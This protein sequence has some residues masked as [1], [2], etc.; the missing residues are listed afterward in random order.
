MFVTA[1]ILRAIYSWQQ[2]LTGLFIIT[3][4][5]F[6]LRQWCHSVTAPNWFRLLPRGL[7]STSTYPQARLARRAYQH[8]CIF[9]RTLLGSPVY[10]AEDVVAPPEGT[11]TAK[12][13][14]VKQYERIYYLFRAFQLCSILEFVIHSYSSRL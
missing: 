11:S 14:L 8:L 2:Q 4:F 6:A 12:L 13:R 10:L 9:S 7:A 1:Q 3:Y 5:Q